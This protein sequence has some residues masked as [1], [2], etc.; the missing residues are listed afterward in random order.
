VRL[1]KRDEKKIKALMKFYA[2]SDVEQAISAMTYKLTMEL[3]AY[4][5]NGGPVNA[6]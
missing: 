3:A 6:E 5:Y 4:I 2:M 1:S